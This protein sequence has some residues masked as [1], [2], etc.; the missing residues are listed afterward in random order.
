MPVDVPAGNAARKQ[1]L[2]GPGCP[3]PVA[4]DIQ[5]LGGEHHVAVFLAFTLLDANEHSLAVNMI[6]LQRNRLRDAQPGRVTG[7]Q[8]RSML[9]VL[10]IG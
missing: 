8:D 7:G 3:P 10:H 9:D 4:Q 6:R 2:N 1:P 5:E